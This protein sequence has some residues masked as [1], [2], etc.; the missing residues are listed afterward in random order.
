MP[1]AP[2]SE[3][4]KS[5]QY[6][7]SGHESF[8]FRYAWLPKA[9]HWIPQKPSL[10]ADE[11]QAMV[12]LGVG[13]NMVRAIRFWA[14]AAGILET[15]GKGQGHRVTDFG[16]KILGSEGAD[17]FLEDIRT[18]WLLH[19]KLSTD[20]DSPL[21]AWDYL[22]NRW[23]HPTLSPS[24]AVEALKKEAAVTDQHLSSTTV[25]QHFEHLPAYICSNSRAKRRSTRRQS[26]FAVSRIGTLDQSRRT[27]SRLRCSPR[28]GLRFS[29]RGKAGYYSRAFRLLCCRLLASALFARGDAAAQSCCDGSRKPR[30]D[31]QDSRGGHSD[32]LG[33]DRSRFTGCYE[34]Q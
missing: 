8:P 9:V 29:A 23:Q 34:F 30:S 7:I 19:W 4:R 6:R 16:E 33:H 17:P 31:I 13:K 21:L 22:L 26:R 14:Q 12:D 11:Q 2:Y 5:V 24:V 10:F 25:Q 15:V 20:V 3:N 27:R 32:A 28:N 18:L 1:S